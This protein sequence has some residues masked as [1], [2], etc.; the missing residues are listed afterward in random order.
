LGEDGTILRTDDGWK[1]WQTQTSGTTNI[2]LSI[3]MSQDGLRGWA[4][5]EGGTILLLTLPDTTPIPSATATAADL[6]AIVQ[7]LNPRQGLPRA[8][9]DQLK[10]AERKRIAAERSVLELRKAALTLEVPPATI[11]AE[12]LTEVFSPVFLRATLTRVLIMVI[13]FF[14]ISVLLTVFRYSLR[15]APQYDGRAD[16]LLLTVTDIDERIHELVR[17]MVPT[18]IDFGKMPRSPAEQVIELAK[19]LAREVKPR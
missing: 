7:R 4:V 6:E 11:E 14:A 12:D 9:L 1:S 5:G 15:M 17:A 2:L 19:E 10:E 16:A 13:V 8:E 3:Q 18:N